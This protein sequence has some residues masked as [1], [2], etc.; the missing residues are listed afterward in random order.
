MCL[1]LYFLLI[2]LLNNSLLL[3]YVEQTNVE[4]KIEF[5]GVNSMFLQYID[6]SNDCKTDAD[7]ESPP[8]KDGVGWESKKNKVCLFP[9][10]Y[11]SIL[12]YGCSINIPEGSIC[13]TETDSDYNPSK[14]GRCNDYCHV[15]CKCCLNT[16]YK[17]NICLSFYAFF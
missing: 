10:R 1:K 12:Y 2:F 7:E 13:A 15:Q 3:V 8:L 5:N 14:V 17:D 4:Q 6:D 16:M 11:N 9:F